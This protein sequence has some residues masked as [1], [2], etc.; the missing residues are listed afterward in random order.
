MMRGRVIGVVSVI[1]GSLTGTPVVAADPTPDEVFERRILPIFRSPNPS[2]CVRCHLHG[3]DLKDYILADAGETFRSL[4]DQGLIDLDAPE[5]SKIIGLIDMG[6][7]EA[8]DAPPIREA[9]RRAERS[10]FLAW[11]KACAADPAQ[12]TAAA[13][14]AGDR[15]AGAGR[16]GPVAGTAPA[17]PL[18][19][20]F[21]DTVWAMRFR[22]MNCHSE[23]TPQNRKLVKEH[24]ARVAWF[25]AEG[26]AATLAYLRMSGLLDAKSPDRS[27]LLLKPLGDVDHGGG[28]KFVVG[29]QGYKAY[30]GFLRDYAAVAGGGTV[31][32]PGDQ[33]RRIGT[34]IWLK[35]TD[36]PAAW[37][38][39]LL[40]VNV[41]AWDAKTR[42]WE[43]SPVATTDRGVGAG[44]WQHNLTVLA[45]P[46][47]DRAQA[48]GAGNETLPVG[49]YLIRVYVDSRNRL[50]KDWEAKLGPD[51]YVGQIEVSSRWPA[52]HGKMTTA[53]VDQLRK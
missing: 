27:L 31:P 5:K 41:H 26:P 46:L 35:L 42:A 14:Q 33:P 25:K 1:V 11:I 29:D 8:A 44:V 7:A 9:V 43:S 6:S 21:E 39:K 24:G 37:K 51:D 52:G 30:R 22:C 40:Q 10:A 15:Q 17:D 3:V 49:K 50:A 4:R 47:R 53:S 12:R 48:G 2:S 38:G 32:D 28:K 34:D 19:Q 20:R 45:P 18:L 23:G 16:T 36:T 13:G